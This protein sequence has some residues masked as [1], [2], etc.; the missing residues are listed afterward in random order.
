MLFVFCPRE[1]LLVDFEDVR[2]R[3][4]LLWSREV[5]L[6]EVEGVVVFLGEMGAWHERGR[7]CCQ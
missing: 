2:C 5:E 6:V 1:G 7:V 3:L 4:C